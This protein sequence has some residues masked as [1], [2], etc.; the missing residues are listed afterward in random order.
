MPRAKPSF[1]LL[2][3]PLSVLRM[4][5]PNNIFV[6]DFP[7]YDLASSRHLAKNKERKAEERGRRERE[8]ER[9][10]ERGGGR[11]REE[12]RER[13]GK[14]GGAESHL[15]LAWLRFKSTTFRYFVG[16][17]MVPCCLALIIVSSASW[18]QTSVIEPSCVSSGESY[19]EDCLWSGMKNGYNVH[20]PG[21]S[22]SVRY[23]Y[24]MGPE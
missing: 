1:F 20:T 2:S 8:R 12:G 6:T 7:G 15:N 11:E 5:T 17:V 21:V 3:V 10:R 13:R 19:P 16:M 23:Q 18:D 9:E 4:R 22:I 24:T 14:G